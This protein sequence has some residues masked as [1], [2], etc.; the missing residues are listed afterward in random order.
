MGWLQ[1]EGGLSQIELKTFT[2]SALKHKPLIQVE[3]AMKMWSR[4]DWEG[5]GAWQKSS[6]AE[7]VDKD[8]DFV[9]S[10]SEREEVPLTCSGI[11]ER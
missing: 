7:E 4:D 8:T 9:F 5:E 1:W 11:R 2:F 10:G 6:K 3:N